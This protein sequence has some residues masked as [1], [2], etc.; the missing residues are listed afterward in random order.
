RITSLCRLAF[1]KRECQSR[2]QISK[3]LLLL[4]N[5][6]FPPP[7]QSAELLRNESI[8]LLALVVHDRYDYAGFSKLASQKTPSK[9]RM[10]RPAHPVANTLSLSPFPRAK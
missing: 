2:W 10:L 6:E 8:Q 7:Q 5:K 1:H 9:N 3:V 4:R